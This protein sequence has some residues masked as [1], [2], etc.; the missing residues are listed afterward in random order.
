MAEKKIVDIIVHVRGSSID[1]RIGQVVLDADEVDERTVIDQRD[2][3]LL[4]GAIQSVVTTLA[5][6]RRDKELIAWYDGGVLSDEHARAALHR[7]DVAQP[8]AV[9]ELP[10][11]FM[12]AFVDVDRYQCRATTFNGRLCKRKRL[13]GSDFC[14][15]HQARGAQRFTVT[16]TAHHT[17]RNT[18]LACVAGNHVH[19]I[20][21]PDGRFRGRRVDP[22]PGEGVD[23]VTFT[24]TTGWRAA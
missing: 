12:P 20:D 9:V 22:C 6:R 17:S 5:E 2:L 18:V 23:R 7:L 8:G 1:Q 11:D 10:P 19:L 16:T 3:D 24:P 13:T 14:K 4:T 15:Q 21:D